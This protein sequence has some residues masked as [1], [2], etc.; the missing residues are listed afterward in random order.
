MRECL[1]AATILS[2]LA[3][4]S[5]GDYRESRRDLR[6]IST[7]REERAPTLD[8]LNEIAP[9]CF[10]A[11]AHGPKDSTTRNYRDVGPGP[12]LRGVDVGECIIQNLL[13]RVAPTLSPETFVPLL[14][15]RTA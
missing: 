13:L 10:I 8:K 7:G 1:S 2:L 6:G 12:R 5:V 3:V 4:A 9:T 15:R 14:L 11:A